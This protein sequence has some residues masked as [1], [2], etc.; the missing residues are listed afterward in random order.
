MSAEP[1]ISRAVIRAYVASIISVALAIAV[2]G[3]SVAAWVVM[4]R[5]DASAMALARALGSELQN[6]AGEPREMNDARVQH[7]LLEHRWFARRV[8]VW[9]AADRIG[10]SPSDGLLGTWAMRDEGC[11]SAQLAGGWHRIC[12]IWQPALSLK[13][14]VASPLSP[15]L[16]ALLPLV[17][18]IWVKSLF[19]CECLTREHRAP[20]VHAAA[21]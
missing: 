9:Q 11:Q 17:F 19:L 4:R 6:H 12:V 21:A 14:V 15:L 18:A 3:S 8:E 10:G 7:E 20:V 2:V 13:I 16:R 1:S 5:D